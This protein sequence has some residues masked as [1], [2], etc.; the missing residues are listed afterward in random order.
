[1]FVFSLTEPYV[2]KTLPFTRPG[3]LVR[4]GIDRL[5][6]AQLGPSL[7]SWQART[8]VFSSVAAVQGNRTLLLTL[9]DQTLPLRTFEVTPSFLQVLQPAGLAPDLA[10]MQTDGATWLFLTASGS[11]LLP[12]H[13]RAPGASLV[14]RDDREVRIAGV[15]PA[16]FVFPD[17]TWMAAIDG[18]IVAQPVPLLRR[19]GTS[20]Y[21]VASRV[22]ARLVPGVS[23]EAAR[24]ALSPADRPGPPVP[25]RIERL[26]D[27]MTRDL[28]PLALGAFGSAVLLLVVCLGFVTNLMIARGLR[29]AGETATREALGASPVEI[30]RLWWCEAFLLLA[31]AGFAGSVLSCLTA[32]V[33]VRTIPTAYLRFGVPY[34]TVDGVLFGAGIVVTVSLAAAVAAAAAARWE[35]R[36]APGRRS[37]R[38]LAVAR[39]ALAAAQAALTLVLAVAAG[40]VVRSYSILTAQ[41]SGYDPNAL[42][43]TVDFTMAGAVD[44]RPRDLA[45]FLEALRRVP[46]V[47]SVSATTGPLADGA[48]SRSAAV[49][50]GRHL[51]VDHTM[52]APGFF[53]ATGMSLVAGRFL[54]D[55]DVPDRGFVVNQAFVERYLGG[56]AAVGYP[57]QVGPSRGRIVGV[58]RDAL[59]HGLA[60]GHRP[61]LF[62]MS[63]PRFVFRAVFIV[64]SD[65]AARGVHAVRDRI[66]AALNRLDRDARVV[67][68]ETL[69]QRLLQTVRQR[70]FGTVMLTGFAVVGMCVSLAGLVM[71]VTFNVARRRREI[72][73]RLVA[74]ARRPHVLALVAGE[75]CVA[76]C[77]GGLVGLLVGRWLSKGLSGLIFGIVPGDW[78]TAT[79]SGGV[80]LATM[81]LTAIASG[82][83][84]TRIAPAIALRME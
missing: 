73:I 16:S 78:A 46:G 55:A 11:A 41:E 33:V 83:R 74:G 17:P 56:Q 48:V 43:A 79:L 82:W 2:L 72:A 14:T 61:T 57:L 66:G 51:L 23:I 9:P 36:V 30:A 75:T 45:P 52:V 19:E 34:I 13:L 76:A 60:N 12:D 15:L 7:E 53:E 6:T 37:P 21:L 39:A 44:P 3:E 80:V 69:G 26:A 47:R 64:R 77:G 58:V 54:G 22:F 28:R 49:V 4:I 35:G 70:T 8:S 81:T 1:M 68:V 10:A 5:A 31:A 84:A 71:M 25:V 20:D 38:R 59:D 18:L 62:S 29:C 24:A 67:D 32:T 63:L 65:G 50:D 40:M 27:V 42:A